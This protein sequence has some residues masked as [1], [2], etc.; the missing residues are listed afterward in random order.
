[1]R[2][3][4]IAAGIAA[5]LIAAAIASVLIF[6]LPKRGE[7][8]ALT[9]YGHALETMDPA[10]C[11]RLAQPDRDDCLV[12]VAAAL[13]D[14][15][16]C[17]RTS[18][19]RGPDECRARITAAGGLAACVALAGD[20]AIAC[21]AQAAASQETAGPADCDALT[22]GL[23]RDRCR[24][25]VA[26]RGGD[27]ES[28]SGITDTDLQRACLASIR[29]DPDGCGQV[30]SGRIRTDCYT[31]LA[32]RTEDAALCERIEDSSLRDDCYSGYAITLRRPEFCDRIV[33]GG[34]R[35]ACAVLA[36]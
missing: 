3:I 17:G 16:I 15:A 32:T 36:G 5:L 21:Y 14:P 28:C 20:A 6:P 34:E 8:V 18:H 12:Q 22:D 25:A 33:D 29:L 35:E 24:F 27:A 26:T 1:M 10:A 11:E 23:E 4:L 2:R 19:M 13:R 7:R 31:S 9:P 30:A